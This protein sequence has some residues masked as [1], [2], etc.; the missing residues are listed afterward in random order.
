MLGGV[1]APDRPAGAVTAARRAGIGSA[2]FGGSSGF[3]EAAVARPCL[4]GSCRVT[5]VG[6][7]GAA[8]ACGEG[9][10]TRLYRGLLLTRARRK[11]LGLGTAD[12]GGT[13]LAPFGK[14]FIARGW[15]TFHLLLF[16][17]RRWKF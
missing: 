8:L 9:G 12:W 17:Q 13:N 16:R 1:P 14:M 15:G 4:G 2:A 11:I 7:S 3:V 10:R 6:G 5:R